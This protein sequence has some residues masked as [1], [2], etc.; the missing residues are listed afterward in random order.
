MKKPILFFLLLNS[1][2]AN[3]QDSLPDFSVI[4]KGNNRIVISWNN[5]FKL[6]KQITI[7]RSAD[8]LSNF[9]SIVSVPDPMNP[10]NGYMDSKAPDDKMFYRLYILVDGSN[11]IFSKSKRAVTDAQLAQLKKEEAVIPQPLKTTTVKP[12]ESPNIQTKNIPAAKPADQK[13]IAP[14][15]NSIVKPIDN[16][17]A[18]EIK[19]DSING[20][21][22][23]KTQT[24]YV[25]RL[26]KIRNERIELLRIAVQQ[27][28]D[29]DLKIS[30][31]PKIVVPVYHIYS[32]GEGTVQIYLKDYQQKKYSIR[33]LEDDDTFL[34]EIKNINAANLKLDKSNFYHSGWFKSELYDNGKLVERNRFFIPK[35]F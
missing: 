18:K 33:F 31:R 27:K 25:I 8:S 16:T 1:I 3:A 6:L 26:K 12:V 14:A 10:Q 2:L 20:N 32:T 19:K 24:D 11:F 29:A 30:T 35:D 21:A 4:N 15:N 28:T 17:P 22:E 34:Y 7:Q 23:N 13:A 9:K 5:R